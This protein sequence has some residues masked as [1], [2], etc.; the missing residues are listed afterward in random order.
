M[1]Y[2]PTLDGMVA[3]SMAS[4]DT[5]MVWW[6]WIVLGAL[7]L[8]AE[9]VLTADFYLVF[10]G[11][12][13]LLMGLLLLLAPAVPVWGQWLLFAALSVIGLVLFRRRLRSILRTSDRPE[14]PELV[15]E[16][17]VVREAVA[18]G[19]R[20][21]VELRGTTWSGAHGGG[22]PLSPGDRCRVERV[23]GLVL[24]VVPVASDP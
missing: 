2:C 11:A 6:G 1:R 18:Q 21:T 19:S 15:G 9:V 13:A 12:A 10:F 20:G 14:L 22:A 7:L 3:G 16:E 23:E 8:G 4:G 5:S 17:G 24:I